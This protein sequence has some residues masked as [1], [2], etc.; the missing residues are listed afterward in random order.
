MI[1]KDNLANLFTSL[2]VKKSLLIFDYMDSS[3]LN[4]IY[5]NLYGE[6]KLSKMGKL[7]METITDVIINM[8]ADKW[9]RS[10]EKFLE[11]TIDI[12][13]G[14]YKLIENSRNE[15]LNN[16]TRS[17]LNKVSAYNDD[18]MAE[19]VEETEEL[20]GNNNTTNDLEK[21]VINNVSIDNIIKIMSY[22]NNY[23]I[24]DIIMVDINS[25]LTLNIY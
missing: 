18:T 4:T 19:D 8:F 10:I 23:Y 1:V 12:T 13:K 21:Q 2:E 17:I 6:K 5:V 15:G 16:L 9:D 7:E 25:I 3:I 24:Y 20:V 14:G 11:T 22:L